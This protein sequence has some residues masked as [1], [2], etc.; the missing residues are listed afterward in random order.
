MAILLA[1]E[2]NREDCKNLLTSVYK[3]EHMHIV[4]HIQYCDSVSECNLLEYLLDFV[5]YCISCANL[6]EMRK[7]KSAREK[8]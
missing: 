7:G 8:R 6:R 2:I 5:I 1:I 3:V 4:K